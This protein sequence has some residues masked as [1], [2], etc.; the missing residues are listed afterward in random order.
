VSVLSDTVSARWNGLRADPAQ[1]PAWLELARDYAARA[2]P[3]Q[4]GYAA[5]QALRLDPGL[6]PACNALRL[7][8]WAGAGAADSQLGRAELEAGAA[9]ALIERFGAAVAACPGD[10]LSWLYLA[11]LQDMASGDTGSRPADHAQRRA[12]RLEPVAGETLHW[13]GVWRLAAGDAAGAIAAMAPLA[14]LPRHGSMMYLADA[15]LRT[16]NRAAAEKAFERASG[17]DNPDFLLTLAHKAYANNYWKEAIAV[18][19]KAL[20]IRPDSIP[21]LLALAQ[22][23]GETYQLDECRGTL[24]RILALEPGNPGAQAHLSSLMGR[25]GDISGQLASLQARYEAGGDPLSRLA[26]SIAMTA[27]Y[28]DQLPAADV[29]ALHRRM[30]AP[31]EAAIGPARSDFPNSRTTGRVLRIGY[32]SSDLHR[33]HPVNLFMLPVL[34]RHDRARFEICVY[35]TGTMH[36]E[37]T[38]QAKACCDRWTEAAALSDAELRDLIARHGIDILVDLGG[39]TDLHRLGMFAQRAAPVQASFLGYPHSTGLSAID[40]LVGDPVVSPAGHAALFSEGIAQLPGSVFCWAPVDDYPLPMPRPAGAPFVFGSFN[41]A[42]KLSPRTV[43]LWAGV[44]RAVP[45]ALLLLKAP[46]L[47]APAVQARYAAL[48]AAHGIGRERLQFRGPSGLEDMMQEYG[49]VDVALDP[50]PYNGGTTTLQALWMGVPVV[51]LTGENFVSRMGT[52]FMHSLGRPEWAAA[53]E[54]AYVAA[55]VALAQGR[56]ALRAGRARLREQMLSSA[57]SDID[58]Y[59]RHFESMLRAMWAS[60][61]KGDECRLL[62]ANEIARGAGRCEPAAALVL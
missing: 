12:T 16:G 18:L 35:H 48:F 25:L 22:M 2:L 10:W 20:V 52:S 56:E 55:A 13:L 61:C 3:W 26:S 33:Q 60:Y 17:S 24:E 44:L 28:H 7:G 27:L 51:S 21:H 4:A 15:L 50:T 54:P 14:D 41:N 43:A 46:S 1:A 32:V 59:V 31:I 49:E 8:D 5:R 57:L 62:A 9:E 38:R 39:H 6:A 45:D 34:L 36:D 30:C 29:A 23:Y 53:S 58:S 42:L 19:H 47:R 40:W 37:Y 11:R